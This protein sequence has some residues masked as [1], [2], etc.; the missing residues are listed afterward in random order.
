M[1]AGNLRKELLRE[2]HETKWAGHPGEERTLAL[3]ARSYY[4]H[5]MGDDVQAY[6]R[7]CLVC[8]LDKTKRK[9]TA[10]LLQP[11]TYRRSLGKASPWI[12]LPGFQR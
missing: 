9:K 1:P 12:L 10:R 7:S 3:L 11:L 5:K 4:W 8:Q 6:V 2:T